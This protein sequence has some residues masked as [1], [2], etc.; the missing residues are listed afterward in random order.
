MDPNDYKKFSS[1][2][3]KFGKTGRDQ[4]NNENIPGP[5]AFDIKSGFTRSGGYK[6]GGS[7]RSGIG[8]EHG[9]PGPG[10]YTVGEFK[11]GEKSQN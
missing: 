9:N 3:V 7:K 10:A 1:A 4:A 8:S 6:F 2:A 11:V 5:G